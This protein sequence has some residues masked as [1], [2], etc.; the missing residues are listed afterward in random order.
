MV[1]V[2]QIDSLTVP[3]GTRLVSAD[4]FETAP[5]SSLGRPPSR[6]MQTVEVCVFLLM[7][8][9]SIVLS[10]FTVG[11]WKQEFVVTAIS[12]VLRDFALCS[13]VLYLVWQ[14][15]EP[16]RSIG[17]TGRFWP[18]QVAIGITL[19]PA[20]LIGALIVAWLF[21]SLGLSSPHTTMRS[22]LSIQSWSQVPLA[23]LLVAV[24]AVAEETI[25][26]GYLLL[27]FRAVTGNLGIA[28]VLSTSIF[29]AGHSYEGVPEWRRSLS[30]A[31]CS[32]PSI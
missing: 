26:R 6:K 10:F 30:W 8:V 18:L 22:A 31:W 29:T 15:D 32:P 21:V 11:Q 1:H 3:K 16:F 12:V 14:H 24:V 5:I 13:L 17:W 20:V 7:I 27:R 9:P 4:A 2:S 19:F 23:V 28:I 25:F